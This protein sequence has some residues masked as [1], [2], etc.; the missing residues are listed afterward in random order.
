ME[1]VDVCSWPC[2]IPVCAG[3]ITGPFNI[4]Q[5]WVEGDVR[6]GMDELTRTG[7]VPLGHL[8]EVLT[9]PFLF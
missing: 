5:D 7:G 4:S 6:S 2:S 3:S 9:G 8:V 1:N